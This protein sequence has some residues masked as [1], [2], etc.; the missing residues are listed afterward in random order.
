M[1]GLMIYM[2]DKP[3]VFICSGEKNSECMGIPNCSSFTLLS[4]SC[5]LKLFLEIFAIRQHKN[6]HGLDYQET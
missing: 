2:V 3:Y 6:Q 1:H 5:F 4:F